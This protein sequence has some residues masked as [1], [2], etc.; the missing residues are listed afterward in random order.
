[1]IS[2]LGE[3]FHDLDRQ[4]HLLFEQ[5]IFEPPARGLYFQHADESQRLR[6]SKAP[7]AQL[8]S[9]ALSAMLKYPLCLSSLTL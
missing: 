4:S 6:S 7:T 1:S 3:Y 2:L 5:G 8:V 9:R